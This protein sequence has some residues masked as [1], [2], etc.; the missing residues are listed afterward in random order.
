MLKV[1]RCSQRFSAQCRF[2]LND[3]LQ[4]LPINHGG[5]VTHFH[6]TTYYRSKDDSDSKKGDS[7]DIAPD[8]ATKYDVFSDEKTTI[9]LDME[10]ERDKMLAGELDIEQVDDTPSIFTGLNTER[11][12]S[13]CRII[14]SIHNQC[15][16]W[17][18][19]ISD[20]KTG[21]FDIEDLVAVLKR[22]NAKDIFVCRVPKELKYVDYM[23]VITARSHRH[24]K[25]MA[26]FVRKMYKIKRNGDEQIPKIEGKNS[27]EWMAI[28]LGN[29]ALHIF[30]APIRKIYD[31]EMLWSVGSKYDCETNKPSDPIFELYDQHSVL[32]SNLSRNMGQKNTTENTLH[33]DD[34]IHQSTLS[35]VKN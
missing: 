29:I 19:V 35:D 25:A 27:D 15:F 12:F 18:N 26:E 7:T 34:V 2:L 23:V 28:D 1:L 33:V 13:K 32:L 6:N 21:V 5:F 9:V 10:E 20:G 14:H 31:L 16:N 11:K 22:E 8:F 4:K 30:S 17:A 3:N 24:M